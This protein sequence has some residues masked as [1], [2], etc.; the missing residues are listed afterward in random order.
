MVYLLCNSE[1]IH[2]L[3]YSLIYSHIFL[4]H[5]NKLEMLFTFLFN[6]SMYISS[7][8]LWNNHSPLSK[9]G[10]LSLLHYPNPY[11]NFFNCFN[12][13]FTLVQKPIQDDAFI[14]FSCPV[15]LGS[16][17]LEHMLSLSFLILTFLGYRPVILQNVPQLG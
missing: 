5:L 8:I 16:W 2:F 4:D 12:N 17:N 15:F 7:E 6:I 9:S 14:V 3:Y 11:S 10:E 1:S 13:L